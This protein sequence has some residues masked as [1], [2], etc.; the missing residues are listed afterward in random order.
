MHIVSH[1]A[2]IIFFFSCVSNTLVCCETRHG[3]QIWISGQYFSST[4]GA[5]VGMGCL[6]QAIV[7]EPMLSVALTMGYI[8]TSDYMF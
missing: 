8:Y 5:S 6:G 3:L 2:V 4:D 1:T 7:C